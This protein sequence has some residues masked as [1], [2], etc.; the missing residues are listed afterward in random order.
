MKRFINNR[1][2]L[3]YIKRHNS[4][5]KNNMTATGNTLKWCKGST[6]RGIC[7]LTNS[8]QVHRLFQSEFTTECYLVLSLSISKGHPVVAYVSFIIFLSLLTSLLFFLQKICFKSVPKQ[9]ANN[10]VSLPSLYCL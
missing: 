4:D 8:R 5:Q 1:T 9:D 10:P 6:I 2:V 3:K 7:S